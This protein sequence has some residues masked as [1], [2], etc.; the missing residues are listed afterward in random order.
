MEAVLSEPFEVTSLTPALG[1]VVTGL[2]LAANPSD[3]VMRALIQLLHARGVVVIPQ[4][5][6]TRA[7]YDRFGRYWGRPLEFFIADHRNPD[8]PALIEINNDPATPEPLRDGAVHWHSDSTYEEEPAAVTMLYGVEAPERGGATQWASTAAAYD[9]LP[10]AMKARLEGLVA[11]HRLGQAPWIEGETQP[12][13]RRPQRELPAQRHPLIVRH[14]VTGRRAIFTSG[15]ACAIEGMDQAE[16]VDLIRSL[17]EHV[18]KPQFRLEY[19]VAAGDV[20]LWD[21]Y[22]TVHT[23]APIE[24]S[25]EEGKRRR[26]F[27]ISTKGLP[28]LVTPVE[29]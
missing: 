17:R 4:Q 19:K 2:D 13:P 7:Q 14:P 22:T 26:L 28:S 9:A 18:V 15:T 20:A 24:Y 16:A 29:A 21:N 8:F 3:E 5:T 25:A 6:L 1:A 11:V 12:D 10:E 27:R 23:A